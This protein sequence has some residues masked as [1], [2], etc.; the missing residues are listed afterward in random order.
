MQI[1]I[2]TQAVGTTVELNDDVLSIHV[3]S[4]TVRRN[5]QVKW[6]YSSWVFAA[7]TWNKTENKINVLLNCTSVSYVKNT[8]ERSY[9]LAS[10][11]PYHRLILGTNTAL[12]SRS[13]KMTID[14]LALWNDVLSKEDLRYIMTSKAGKMQA[15]SEHGIACTEM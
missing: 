15:T 10:V 12:W 13:V 7:I 14:E 9:D 4:P 6:P 3:N 8:V 1:A 2:A 5:V 11:L